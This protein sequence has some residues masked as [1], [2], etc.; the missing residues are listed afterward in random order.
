MLY[1]DAGLDTE[2]PEQ[3]TLDFAAVPHIAGVPRLPV[4]RSADRRLRRARDF[5]GSGP[6][7][8]ARHTVMARQPGPK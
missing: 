1:A 8:Q 4:Q 5:A 7:R 2:S 3:T 6:P